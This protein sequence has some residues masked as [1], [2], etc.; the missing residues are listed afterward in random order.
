MPRQFACCACALLALP[1]LFAP[2]P[3]D[4]Q[5]T[6]AIAGTV[7]DGTGS[8][9]QNAEVRIR[10]TGTAAERKLTSDQSGRFVG[11]LLPVGIYDV[12]VSAPGFKTASQAGIRLNVADRL[13]LTIRLEVG[14]VTD[15][16]QV[17]AEAPLIKT[18]T[19][20]LG[21]H[22]TT[23]Q[24]TDLAISN[25]NFLAL[26]QLIPGASRTVGDEP[27]VGGWSAGKGFAINGHRDKYSGTMLDGVQNTDMGSQ[28]G[29]LVIPGLE[30]IGEVQVLSSNYSAEH[31]VAGG[32][33][34]IVVTRS[35]TQQFH[36]AAYE[37]IRNDAL[38]ARNFFSA[39]KPSQRLNN[40]GFRLGGPL[41]IP[42]KYN[43][44][45][46][47]TFF[48]VSEEWRLRRL[49]SLVRATAPTAA[50]RQGDFSAEAARLNKPLRDLGGQPL[51]GDRIPASLMNANARI[52]LDYAFPLPNAPGVANN[53]VYN[54]P[55]PENWRQDLVRI[56]HNFT[57]NT[58]ANFR[59]IR[60]SW[61]ARRTQ[62][63]DT[64]W[65]EWYLPAGNYGGRVT[66][67]V[68]PTMVTDFSFNYAYN[69]GPRD[70]AT[71]R[72]AGNY[73]APEGLK[74]KRLFPLPPERPVKI[75]DLSFSAGWTGIGSGYYPW[76]AHHDI[77]TINNVTTK[78]F[79]SHSLK[80]GAEYQFSTSP[81]Q[82]QVNP[83]L[84][85]SFS[86]S[87]SF[88]NH[89]VADFLMG[90]ASSYGELNGWLEPRYDYHQFEAFVQDDWKVTRKLSLNL[91]VRY[92]YIP[93]SNEKDDLL[94]VFRADQYDRTK[95]A[96]VLSNGNIVPDSGDMLNGMRG[97]KD[98]LPR[99]LVR[100]H[101]W[102]FGPRFGF[103][104]DLRGN[105]QTV[106][107][108][109]YGVGYY[110]VEGNDVYRLVGNPP[111]A[112][113]VNVFNPP[114]DDPTKGSAGAVLP[115]AVF[116]LDPV[117]DVPMAQTYSFGIQRRLATNTSFSASYVGSRGTHLDRGRQLNQP[118]PV[119]NFEFDTR[120]N[121]RQVSTD[122]LRPYPGYSNITMMEN[123][124]SSTYHSLQLDFNRQFHKG[125]HLQVVYT[126]SKTMADADGFGGTPQNPY[127]MKLER[128]LTA[129]DRPHMFV[130]NYMYEL[131]FW[132]NAGNPF[133][134]ALA[135]WQ[136]GG[137]LVI[138]S[139]TPFS[140]GLSGSTN[141][142]ATRPD[143]VAGQNPAG[144]R[145]VEKWFNTAAFVAPVY[146]YYGNAGRNILRG[147]GMVKWDVSLLKDFRI[148]ESV[149]LQFRGEA[150]NVLNRANFSGVSAAVGSPNYGM[151]TSARDPRSI[152]LG[153]KLEF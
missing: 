151:I 60:E 74:I 86:F 67:V 68:N 70:K 83:S 119:G 29:Q 12:H 118:M 135:G 129:F 88:T 111:R 55:S 77:K 117:Y 9:V 93:H 1:L 62:S 64:I 148:G 108:G 11:D 34:V 38:N 140:P 137:I 56:D 20:E 87:G 104:Y 100:N 41:F 76:W 36:G 136:L 22:I 84:Q 40:F 43:T 57:T 120:L 138:Q 37:Y 27:A 59:M 122:Y 33:N 85:G 99:G 105:S 103:A 123:T 142:L 112:S 28:N 23:K 128:S 143:V 18:E 49:V 110:R 89:P 52:L 30:T 81:V 39:T 16:V 146:G 73:L 47:K 134:R 31:G 3:L 98:G 82:S 65:Q 109:G 94:T 126:L 101:P 92:F 45:R 7:V 66:K 19:G 26:Q 50:M 91:G 102:K 149:I 61:D 14:Q 116:T 71:I 32:A 15:S 69:Y 5:T 80:F 144:P 53:F 10:N 121:T 131:P 115:R 63:Y 72:S 48:F 44:S 21:F 4:A 113:V 153:L 79:A 78:T 24:V 17:T 6:G 51:P 150:F 8:V 13:G 106:L 107:R 152:Q 133:Q 97:V 46:E 132:R 54:F 139:G 75:P 147:P 42:G 35:G 127:N 141:G 90:Q 25:R 2:V 130:T 124:A 125:L 58:R 114:L 96:S 145:T 95:A